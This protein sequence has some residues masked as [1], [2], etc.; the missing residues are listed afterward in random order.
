MTA[1]QERAAVVAAWRAAYE[2]A[3]GFEPTHNI[4]YEGG[5]F[6]FD[7]IGAGANRYRLKQVVEMTARLLA[8]PE[9]IKETSE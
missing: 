4:R 8:R 7:S 1:E 3:N 5:W 9:H 6:I 2:R